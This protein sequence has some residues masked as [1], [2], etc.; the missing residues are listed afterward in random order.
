MKASMN[1]GL[2]ESLKAAFPD[3]K[4]VSRPLVENQLIL[5]PN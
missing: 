1:L 4:P 3:I 2:S 5:D